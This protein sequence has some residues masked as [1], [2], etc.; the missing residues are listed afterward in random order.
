MSR[1]SVWS[2]GRDGNVV[3]HGACYSASNALSLLEELRLDYGMRR[4]VG[5][6][7]NEDPERGDVTADLEEEVSK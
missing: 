6:T 2:V 5:I 4:K 3:D 1:Y 7:D